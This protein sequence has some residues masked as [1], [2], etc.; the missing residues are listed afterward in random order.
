VSPVAER[1]DAIVVGAGPAGSTAAR[2]LAEE[3]ASVLL[4]DRSRFP[5]DKPCGG[6][7]TVRAARRLPFSLAPVV[8]GAVDSLEVGLGYERR[9][10]RTARGPLVFMTE[11]RE[12]D[13]FLAGRAAEAGAELRE[14][15]KVTAVEQDAGCV[16]VHGEG[17][18][19]TAPLLVG[20]DG[21]NGAT[22]RALGAGAARRLCVGLEADV[23]YGAADEERYR[24]RA[25]LELGVVAG[26]YAWVFPKREHVNV[27]VAAWESEGPRLRDHLGR[28]LAHH[29]LPAD[30]LVNVRGYR[31]PHRAAGSPLARGRIALAGDAAG[32][33]D[34]LSGDG[35]YE[36]FASAGVAA[37]AALDLLG[38]RASS[39]EP[40]GPALLEELGG[41]T[42]DS[43]GWKLAFDRF[44]RVG[45]A[46]ARAPL[47]WPTIQRLL[48]GELYDAGAP[49]RADRVPLLALAALARLAGDPGRPYR[50]ELRAGTPAPDP[51][52]PV[53][54]PL[55]RP[56]GP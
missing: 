1:F 15:V 32:L 8:Q 38:G 28:L 17:L 33:V 41:Q 37:G 19:A 27:G 12:L 30:A 18:R 45:Y 48:R 54:A 46:V 22:A 36:A 10:R 13:A 47:A 2:L 53:G 42:A 14:G 34:P 29:R 23:P 5:R 9:F 31:L 4:L 11:R 50:R 44:P 7:V 56:V 35:I 24:G 6:G 40:Y 3:G 25:V 16:S 49:R 52:S 43:W 39:L 21:V 26:G 51:R 55:P 20:A